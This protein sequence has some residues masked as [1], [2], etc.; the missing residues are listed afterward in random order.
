MLSC[1]FTSFHPK[2][3]C[4]IDRIGVTASV[5]PVGDREDQRWVLA[6]PGPDQNETPHPG[7]FPH[8]ERVRERISGGACRAGGWGRES[9]EC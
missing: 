7:P 9:S 2:A 4:D 8:W 3:L 5:V 1:T 6:F